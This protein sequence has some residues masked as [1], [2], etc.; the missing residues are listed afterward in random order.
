[1]TAKSWKKRI[2]KA[3]EN[4]GTYKDCFD[5]VIETL[6]QIMEERDEARKA[7][8]GNPIVEHTNQG[9]AT[10]LAQNPAL[11]LINDLNRDALAYWRELGLTPKGLRQINE[12]AIKETK[13]TSALERALE[14][15]GNE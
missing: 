14:M 15:I 10:N 5:S 9:G 11:R 8:D 1:M 12:S 4:A 13:Q 6:S 3:C 2:K 7:Y